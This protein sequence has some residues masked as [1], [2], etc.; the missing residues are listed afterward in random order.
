MSDVFIASDNILSPIGVTTA[1][2]FMQLTKN[3]SGIQL[4]DN[5]ALSDQPFYASLFDDTHDFIK[6]NGNSAYTR[7]EQL[8]IASIG[9]ALENSGIDAGDKKTVLIISST[10]G[11]I[12][13]LE[14]HVFD[15]AL[16]KRIALHT[17]AVF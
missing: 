15:P 13:L 3:I 16:K 8:L 6:D 7:F 4:H 17:S 1:E 2:N 9:N 11:N 12:S 5:K 10:K 14:T